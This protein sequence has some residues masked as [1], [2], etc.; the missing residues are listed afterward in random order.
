MIELQRSR[1]RQATQLYW[2]EVHDTLIQPHVR[3]FAFKAYALS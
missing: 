1:E 3:A 2:V